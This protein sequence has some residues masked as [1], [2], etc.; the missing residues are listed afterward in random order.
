MRDDESSSSSWEGAMGG[1][2]FD[3]NEGRSGS[4]ALTSM[5]MRRMAC[6]LLISWATAAGLDS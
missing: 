4:E 5:D 2:K 6:R 3:E 1:M